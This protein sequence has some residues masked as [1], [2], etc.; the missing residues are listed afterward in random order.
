MSINL[1]TR[2]IFISEAQLLTLFERIANMKNR[3]FHPELIEKYLS[4]GF[5]IGSKWWWTVADV[6]S[7]Y[8]AVLEAG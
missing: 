6:M 4:H 5:Q 2:D 1:D 3:S 8:R 7:Y